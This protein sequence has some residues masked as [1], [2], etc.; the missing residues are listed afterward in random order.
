MIFVMILSLALIVA[1]NVWYWRK[2]RVMTPA[3][4]EHHNRDMEVDNYT[5]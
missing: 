5:W 1:V 3:E 2:L 4:R